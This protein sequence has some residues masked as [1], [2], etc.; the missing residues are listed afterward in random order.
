MEYTTQHS[1]VYATQPTSVVFQNLVSQWEEGSKSFQY[2]LELMLSHGPTIRQ[3]EL[4][5]FHIADLTIDERIYVIVP[6]NHMIEIRVASTNKVSSSRKQT[7]ENHSMSSKSGST[8]I[9]RANQLACIIN[10]SMAR[11]STCKKDW[12]LLKRLTRQYQK[13]K[14]SYKLF[15]QSIWPLYNLAGIEQGWY[16]MSEFVRAVRCQG[17]TEG[18]V[19][20]PLL[21]TKQQIQDIDAYLQTYPKVNL[22]GDEKF[23]G[24][25]VGLEEF[26]KSTTKI[27]PL[28]YN[29][30]SHDEDS[31]EE[32]SLNK[33]ALTRDHDVEY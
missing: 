15:R 9:S 1:K 12:K 25:N 21:F 26:L 3:K 14:Y 30:D 7:K 18:L 11:K 8:T 19:R 24:F 23:R 13:P 6:E 22:G 31:L 2:D 16:T 10:K 27:I 33:V 29:E 17:L 20:I 28:V 4:H 5:S 32:D